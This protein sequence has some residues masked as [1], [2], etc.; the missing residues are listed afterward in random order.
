[1][2]QA[3]EGMFGPEDEVLGAPLVDLLV[4]PLGEARLAATVTRAAL[5]PRDPEVMPVR[6]LAPQARGAGTMAA[7]ISTCGP[8]R[9]ALVTVEPSDFGT[10]P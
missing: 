6:G 5:R 2:S 10:L 9:A 8:P 4:S 7:R 1:M 3:A